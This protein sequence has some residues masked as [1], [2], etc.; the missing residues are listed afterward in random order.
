MMA[1]GCGRL[2]PLSSSGPNYL[3]SD[4][5][6]IGLSVP[7]E[8]SR[9]ACCHLT[10]VLY[11]CSDCDEP[12]M[13]IKR[14][15]WRSRPPGPVSGPPPTLGARE[16]CSSCSRC[17]S[18]TEPPG[19]SGFPLKVSLLLLHFQSN[20]AP[21]FLSASQHFDQTLRLLDWLEWSF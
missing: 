4:V 3:V 20:K 15:L 13:L 17:V 1:F 16:T 18:G 19:F 11:R 10:T 12:V 7:A 8:C 21:V 9:S 2:P 5:S 14:R 6:L